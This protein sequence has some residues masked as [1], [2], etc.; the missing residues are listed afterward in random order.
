[1]IRRY[2]LLYFFVL[3]I[4]VFLGFTAWQSN[5]YNKLE[6]NVRRLE[7]VQEEWITGNSKLIANI[8]VLSSSGRIEQIALHDLGLTKIQPEN[9]LQVRIGY[10]DGGFVY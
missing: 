5:N 2:L 9:V 4:P 8:A 10:D 7:A 3:T 1:M 6:K